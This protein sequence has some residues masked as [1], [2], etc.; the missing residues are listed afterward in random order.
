MRKLP[1][2]QDKTSNEQFDWEFLDSLVTDNDR[3]D[4]AI[5]NVSIHMAALMSYCGKNRNQMAELLAVNR[6]RIT[7]MLK[8][9]KNLQV[10]TIYKFANVLGYQFD[11]VF[12]KPDESPLAQPWSVRPVSLEPVPSS[13]VTALH[14][15]GQIGNV[16][17]VTAK[18][19]LE[20]SYGMM[21]SQVTQKI[22]HEQPAILSNAVFYSTVTS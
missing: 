20:H 22:E 13:E 19:G 2:T 9:A 18:H 10:K 5:T 14:E 8:G 4:M 3:E 1:S 12:R 6:S 17:F 7:A 16:A 21:K 11:V 15:S